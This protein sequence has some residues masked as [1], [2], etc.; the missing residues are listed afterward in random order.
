MGTAVDPLPDTLDPEAQEGDKRCEAYITKKIQLGPAE[1]EEEYEEVFV[2]GETGPDKTCQVIIDGNAEISAGYIWGSA[3]I[4]GGTIESRPG[5]SLFG[6]CLDS[7][8]SYCVSNGLLSCTCM[9]RIFG[10][11]VVSGNPTISGG[12]IGDKTSGSTV[13][14]EGKANISGNAQITGGTIY[15]G[16]ISGS[17][18]IQG[19]R[20]SYA[21]NRVPEISGGT[22][23]YA[24]ISGGKITGGTFRKYSKTSEIA[25]NPTVG[26][27]FGFPICNKWSKQLE[28]T[29]FPSV[30]GGTIGGGSFRG[31]IISGGDICVNQPS[32]SVIVEPGHIATTKVDFV[33]PI[34]LIMGGIANKLNT[35]L[36]EDAYSTLEEK[37]S[38]S[39]FVRITGG[40]ISDDAK[41]CGGTLSS[42]FYGDGTR[43]FG[44]FGNQKAVKCVSEPT[45]KYG[46][47]CE[48]AWGCRW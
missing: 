38:K 29:S 20:I 5:T 48:C 34:H 26:W 16:N 41:I 19:G 17:A 32:C 12:I 24:D 8:D 31:G 46:R 42:G 3:N 6:I 45:A 33:I 9:P 15:G 11:T 14:L 28:S 35:G 40:T 23:S 7:S 4:Q 39:T 30:T 21:N 13:V 44:S 22:I 27:Y 10:K 1:G 37:E 43:Y 25:Y 2:P 36:T 47:I 18:K